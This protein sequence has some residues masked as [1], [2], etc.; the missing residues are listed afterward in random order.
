MKY[1]PSERYGTEKSLQHRSTLTQIHAHLNCYNSLRVPC[2][3]L[4]VFQSKHLKQLK[5]I[6][7]QKRGNNA[8][9]DTYFPR[10]S[11]FLIRYT[12][13]LIISTY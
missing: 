7:M 3:K 12:F 2:V 10:L 8:F 9:H 13:F 4:L 11:E 1:Y 5:L 6:L